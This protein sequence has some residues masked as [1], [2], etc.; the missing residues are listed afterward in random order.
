MISNHE[1]ETLVV[2]IRR[3]TR[4]E[5][6]RNDRI[7]RNAGNSTVARIS[8]NHS[9]LRIIPRARVLQRIRIRRHANAKRCS[10]ASLV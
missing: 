2:N 4:D 9:I 6:P 5:S 7:L 1:K 10:S 8:T 3:E